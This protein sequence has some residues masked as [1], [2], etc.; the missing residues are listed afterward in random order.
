MQGC[1]LSIPDLYVVPVSELVD[2][3]MQLLVNDNDTFLGDWD[4]TS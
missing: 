4:S 1:W 3:S 2:G